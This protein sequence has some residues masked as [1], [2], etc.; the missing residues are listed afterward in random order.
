MGLLLAALGR[1]T[2]TLRE[3]RAAQHEL[4][5][6]AVAEERH[7]VARDLHDIL[8][9]GLTVIAIK[10]EL[11]GRLERIDPDRAERES[12]ELEELARGAL[13]DVRAT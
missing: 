10:A 9:H 13:A 3:L 12:A 8:G 7:R 11:A 5:E 4:A 2:Q 6:L 1:Q